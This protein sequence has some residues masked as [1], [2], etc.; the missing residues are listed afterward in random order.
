M[1]QMSGEL[2][3]YDRKTLKCLGTVDAHMTVNYGWS[4]DSRYFLTAILFPRLRVDNGYRIWSCA[5]G[6]L[7]SERIEELTIASWR[8]QSSSLFPPP[9]DAD[10]RAFPAAASGPKPTS[11]AAKYVPPGQRAGSGGPGGKGLSLSDLAAATGGGGPGFAGVY[12][13]HQQPAGR[14]LSALAAAQAAGGSAALRGGPPPGSEPADGSG[15]SRNAQKQKAK[16]EAARRKKEEGA[17]EESAAPTPPPTAPAASASGGDANSAEQV[18]KK[19][20]NVEKKLR[21][22]AELKEL[23]TGG[24]ELE[25][26]QLDKIEAEATV[27]AELDALTTKLK[28]LSA[29]AEG[30]KWR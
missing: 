16:R 18:T 22:I 2:S 24:R 27:K 5:G 4:P 20:R 30:E 7:H 19:I 21:Q 10:A 12:D 15:T 8:P 9:D 6:L 26:N 17:V 1:T 25:K 28:E 29:Q 23:K 14:S 13:P 3:F 11:K